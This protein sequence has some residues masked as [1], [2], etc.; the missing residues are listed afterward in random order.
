[1]EKEFILEL[2]NSPTADGTPNAESTK[3]SPSIV[4]IHDNFRLV[5]VMF[6]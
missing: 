1:M 3:P 2:V 4:T 5:N 6:C